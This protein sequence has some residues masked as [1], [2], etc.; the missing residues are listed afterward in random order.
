MKVNFGWV[1]L[2]LLGAFAV[3]FGSRWNAGLADLFGDR[4]NITEGQPI[5]AI[6]GAR[7]G[8][9]V[10]VKS[11]LKTIRHQVVR[12][13]SWSKIAKKYAVADYNELARYHHF[14]PLKPGMVLEIPA[15]LRENQ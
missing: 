2:L 3:L 9:P 11:Q 13:D 12:G 7:A 6:R 5:E 14:I 1:L 15:E 10:A 4:I 8:K